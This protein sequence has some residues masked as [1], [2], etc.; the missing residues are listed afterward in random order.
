[1]LGTFNAT[2]YLLLIP[3]VFGVPFTGSVLLLCGAT[4]RMRFQRQS[5]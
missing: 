1:M 5:G 2:I 4:I 3:K